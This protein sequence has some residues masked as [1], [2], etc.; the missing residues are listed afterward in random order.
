MHGNPNTQH[1]HVWKY[2][3]SS[4]KH[5]CDQEIYLCMTNTKTCIYIQANFTAEALK[6]G[7]YGSSWLS[8][9]KIAS[10]MVQLPSHQ[11]LKI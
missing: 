8:T 5:N 7:P 4:V 6:C 9:H 2:F 3:P 1:L 10:M 11:C